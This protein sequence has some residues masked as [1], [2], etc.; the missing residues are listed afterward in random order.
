MCVCEC[1]SAPFKRVFVTNRQSCAQPLPQQVEF[2]CSQGAIDAVILREKDLDAASYKLLARHVADVC[3]Q[4]GIGFVVH[5]QVDI[6]RRLGC[7]SVH[8]PLPQLRACGRPAGFACVGT[9]VHAVDEVREAEKL[10]AD[11]L[12]ASPIFA[13]SCKPASTAKGLAFLRTVVECA[14][15]PVFA[16]GGIDDE[17]EAVV[18]VCGAAGAC[19]MA[20]YTCR[21]AFR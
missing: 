18:R 19:R 4:C 21:A 15:V 5:T 3:A 12:I 7:D 13:P 2:L 14:Q 10:G 9:N 16:L 20:D 17:K 8:V 1:S 6:A 11:V